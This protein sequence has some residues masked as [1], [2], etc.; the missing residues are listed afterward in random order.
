MNHPCAVN[1]PVNALAWPISAVLVLLSVARP[2]TLAAAA[3]EQADEQPN[4][5]CI[6][7][8]P[9]KTP[10]QQAIYERM[11]EHRPL[12][13]FQEIFSPFRL[14]IE[15]TL[16]VKDCD[17]VSNAWYQRPVVT[18]CYEY[19]ADFRKNGPKGDTPPADE[20]FAGITDRCDVRAVLFCCCT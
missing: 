12:E 3:N 2:G 8:G 7:Y 19:V 16:R 18:I 10:E 14:P 17:G 6:E 9:P 5:I 4:R 1:A 11:M 13:K 15:V 20:V